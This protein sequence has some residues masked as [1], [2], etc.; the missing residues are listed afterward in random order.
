MKLTVQRQPSGVNGGYSYLL[1]DEK[2]EPLPH[3]LEVVIAQTPEAASITVTFAIDGDEIA[4][5]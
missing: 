2:G 4:L 1:C 3:Q 5:A